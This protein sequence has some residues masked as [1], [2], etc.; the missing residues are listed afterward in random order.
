M[1]LLPRETFNNLQ[2]APDNLQETPDD[3]Q[4]APQVAQ[5]VDDVVQEVD[6]NLQE[7][8]NDTMSNGHVPPSFHLKFA[9]AKRTS[10]AMKGLNNTEATTKAKAKKAASDLAGL[11]TL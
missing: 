2:E 4:D 9:N 8:D 1:A 7:A 6:D 5:E 11:S 10:E 3:P